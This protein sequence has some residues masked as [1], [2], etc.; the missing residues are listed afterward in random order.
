MDYVQLL[1]I[2]HVLN[3]GIRLYT[4]PLTSYSTMIFIKATTKTPASQWYE[5]DVA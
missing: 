2:I 5:R 1:G 4:A 3:F